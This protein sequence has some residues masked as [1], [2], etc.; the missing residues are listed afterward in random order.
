MERQS[1]GGR[2]SRAQLGPTQGFMV[3][4]D[5]GGCHSKGNSEEQNESEL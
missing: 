3:I 2:L 5:L 4:Q 1:S